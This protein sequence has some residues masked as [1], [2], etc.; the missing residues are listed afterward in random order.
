MAE[1][2]WIC[3][4]VYYICILGTVKEEFVDYLIKESGLCHHPLPSDFLYDNMMNKTVVFL[5]RDPYSIDI[6]NKLFIGS[7]WF[8]GFIKITLPVYKL[9]IAEK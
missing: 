3:T 8:F 5:W 4:K 7:I 9:C 6:L 2:A 1:Y